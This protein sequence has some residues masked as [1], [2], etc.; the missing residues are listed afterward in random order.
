MCARA[1]IIAG[2]NE[3]GVALFPDKLL[4]E[5]RVTRSSDKT[6]LPKPAERLSLG[7]K[8]LEVSPICLGMTASVATVEAAFEA[9]VNFFFVSA[10]LHWPYYDATR[11]GL[12]RLLKGNPRR[13]D[14]IVV[15][16]V[17]YFEEPWFGHLQFWEVIEAVPGLKCVDLLIAGGVSSRWSFAERVATLRKAKRARHLGS[18]AIGASMHQRTLAVLAEQERALDISYIR[19]NAAHP[20]ARRDVLPHLPRR[21]RTLLFNFKSVVSEIAPKGNGRAARQPSHWVPE[22]TDYYRFVLSASE[23]DG[24]LC[25]PASPKEL[26]GLV[27]ALD[28]G[29]L[30]REEQDEM[31]RICAPAGNTQDW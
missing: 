3:N 27:R 10:D 2:L 14:Q 22:P 12:A 20:G 8:G 18:R 25:S 16:V 15:G 4:A 7:S 29:P 5:A 26:H 17:S 24:V 19:Y 11:R 30:G 9:G 13:R 6:A 21:R 28:K 1:Y 23:I 31:I